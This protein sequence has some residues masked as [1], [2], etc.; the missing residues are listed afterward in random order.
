[1]DWRDFSHEM[2]SY[3]IAEI[4]KLTITASNSLLLKVYFAYL[5]VQSDDEEELT[6]FER[7]KKKFIKD[8]RQ[9]QP[10]QSY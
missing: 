8:N 4:Y 9:P 10:V 5:F 6:P 7:M 3:H 2:G 1:M